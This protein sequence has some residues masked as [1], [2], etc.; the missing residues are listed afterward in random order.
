M[1]LVV[2]SGKV[3]GRGEAMNTILV[4]RWKESTA[5]G[6]REEYSIGGANL[7]SLAKS[8]IENCGDLKGIIWA[9]VRVD[10]HAT[11]LVEIDEPLN[12]KQEGEV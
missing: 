1:Y 8:I 12:E 9:E 6:K 7:E 4:K 10:A 11:V 3:C 2:V 5:I